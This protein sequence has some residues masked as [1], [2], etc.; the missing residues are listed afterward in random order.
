M[1]LYALSLRKLRLEQLT[2]YV[3]SRVHY[4]TRHVS[5][6]S[7]KALQLTNVNDYDE[8]CRAF[9]LNIFHETIATAR[10]DAV[11]ILKLEFHFLHKTEIYVVQS[12]ALS[13][14]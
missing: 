3:T 7:P 9:L 14:S 11:S 6:R 13:S 10:G 8:L 5:P 2:N 1:I 12:N 4:A